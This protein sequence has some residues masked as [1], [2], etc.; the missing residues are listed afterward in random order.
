MLTLQ[1]AL[2]RM[3]AA[4]SDTSD[5]W[6]DVP[7]LPSL[8]STGDWWPDVPGIPGTSGSAPS[9]S[10]PGS[11]GPTPADCEA[12]GARYD[13]ATGQCVAVAEFPPG[14]TIEPPA[15]PPTF[16]R[17]S[18]PPWVQ[19]GIERCDAE[20]KI[21]DAAS[22]SCVEPDC[23]DGSRWSDETYQC[24]KDDGGEPVPP[25]PGPRPGPG[26]GPTSRPEP[27]SIDDETSWSRVVIGAS[28]GIVAGG[29]GGAAV[30]STAM[31]KKK[32]P[33]G[34]IIGALIGGALGA[35]IAYA[36]RQEAKT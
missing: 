32:V 6:P 33:A 2:G 11:Y 17:S 9:P 5:W 14:S 19:Q 31:K 25:A 12:A 13:A 27:A 8:P 34:A 28:I 4:S 24:Q 22:D 16:D 26:T 20:G 18:L 7:E 10:Q 35:G 15:E 36:T 29:G 23:P 1:Q 21:Y 30:A 3:A